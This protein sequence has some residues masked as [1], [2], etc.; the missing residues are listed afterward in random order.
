[1]EERKKALSLP[2]PPSPGLAVHRSPSKRA[3]I[4]LR[5]KVERKEKEERDV[6]AAQRYAEER[7]QEVAEVEQQ[8]SEVQ[9]KASFGRAKLQVLGSVV[10]LR[11]DMEKL[12]QEHQNATAEFHRA[13][14]EGNKTV[15]LSHL[16][17]K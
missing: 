17:I 12:R 13:M 5:K 6:L 14:L 11:G 1:M 2:P 10:K 9:E 8:H 3:E 16:Y 15:F 7:D 4:M